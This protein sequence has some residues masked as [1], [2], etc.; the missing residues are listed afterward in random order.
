MPNLLDKATLIDRAGSTH[1][2]RRKQPRASPAERPAVE[3]LAAGSSRNDGSTSAADTGIVHQP[4]AVV[5]EAPVRDDKDGPRPQ[6]GGETAMPPSAASAQGMA[7]EFDFGPVDASL[8]N[9]V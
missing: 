5:S 2:S 6:G 7:M 8:L 1:L 3:T 4:V 9:D